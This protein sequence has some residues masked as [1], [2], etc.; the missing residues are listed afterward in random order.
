MAKTKRAADTLHQVVARSA[1]DRFYEVAKSPA[2]QG[3][4]RL[5]E[6]LKELGQDPVIA[7]SSPACEF[8][9][10]I[11]LLAEDNITAQSAIQALADID[12]LL[13]M[14]ARQA[15]FEAERGGNR[16][17]VSPKIA[18]FRGLK[19]K[20]PQSGPKALAEY[21]SVTVGKGKDAAIDQCF[22]VDSGRS[23][24]DRQRGRAVTVAGLA[25]QIKKALQRAK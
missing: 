3:W 15:A 19:D 25:E 8:L 22:M 10:V 12:H 20:F 24:I 17:S 9:K 21:I 1:L 14:G 16:G 11:T 18:L 4:I 13:P 23:L 5:S 7:A 2:G 6:R